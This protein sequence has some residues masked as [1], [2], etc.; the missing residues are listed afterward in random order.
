[1]EH[2]YKYKLK[3]GSIL[4]KFPFDLN[5][6]P[7]SLKDLAQNMGLNLNNLDLDQ[8]PNSAKEMLK[9]LDPSM[10]QELLSNVDPATLSQLLGSAMGMLNDSGGNNDALKELLKGF[11]GSK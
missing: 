5:M 10:L 8:L 2:T 1:M 11:L 7:D 4:E 6:L 3:G 9:N